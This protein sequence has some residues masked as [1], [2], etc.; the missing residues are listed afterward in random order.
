MHHCLFVADTLVVKMPCCLGTGDEVTLV[1]V[2]REH[3][4]VE[5]PILDSLSDGYHIRDADVPV[6]KRGRERLIGGHDGLVRQ[7]IRVNLVTRDG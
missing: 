5:P 1:G 3:P 7:R 6:L 4:A 2:E